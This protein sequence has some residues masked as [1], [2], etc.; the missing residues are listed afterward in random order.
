VPDLVVE[1]EGH[2]DLRGGLRPDLLG[3][4]LAQ[5]AHGI[6]QLVLGAAGGQQDP[7]QRQEQRRLP[8]HGAFPIPRDQI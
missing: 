6:E 2:L 4:L 7:Q 3:V 8:H 1:L 5:V